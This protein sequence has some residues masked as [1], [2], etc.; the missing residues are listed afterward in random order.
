VVINHT[1]FPLAQGPSGQSWCWGEALVGF[2]LSAGLAISAL[3]TDMASSNCS[4]VL[5]GG[6][7]HRGT[8]PCSELDPFWFPFSILKLPC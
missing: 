7:Q 4:E 5:P 6:G 1:E 8:L 3:R 2:I